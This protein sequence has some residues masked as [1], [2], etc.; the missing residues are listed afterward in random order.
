MK[1]PLRYIWK[2]MSPQQQA[3]YQHR[4]RVERAEQENSLWARWM[5]QVC[6]SDHSQLEKQLKH[7]H[8]TAVQL[9]S[10]LKCQN[11]KLKDL[12]LHD[13][14]PL[15][16]NTARQ[17]HP[18]TPTSRRASTTLER[19]APGLTPQFLKYSGSCSEKSASLF[20]TGDDSRN[21]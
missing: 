8:L 3:E 12:I 2:D 17:I 5:T 15:P 20:Q 9:E 10:F 11:R 1:S 6:F 14:A 7:P 21:D 19:S 4:V 16:A 13:E 18:R